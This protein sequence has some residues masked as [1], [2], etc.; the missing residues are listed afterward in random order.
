MAIVRRE[1]SHAVAQQPT[2][3]SWGKDVP[4]S[5]SSGPFVEIAELKSV[6]CCK[7]RES[8]LGRPLF[9]D[10]A[11]SVFHAGGVDFRCSW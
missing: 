10:S 1:A 2:A 5:G 9:P 6:A 4:C 8:N 11:F 3:E 7:A